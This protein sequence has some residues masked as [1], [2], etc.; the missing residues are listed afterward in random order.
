VPNPDNKARTPKGVDDP[1]PLLSTIVRRLFSGGN[2]V[3]IF[4][5]L[6]LDS[7][8]AKRNPDNSPLLSAQ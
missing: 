3:L 4:V 2:Y 7:E 6:V 1:V 5:I 8:R